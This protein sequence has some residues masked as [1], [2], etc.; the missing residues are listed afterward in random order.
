MQT[1]DFLIP[2]YDH[3]FMTL[4]GLIAK[5][6]EHPKGDALLGA[7]LAEDMLPLATQIRFL[8]NMPGE[9]LRRL[10]GIDFVSSEEDDTT[11]DQAARRVEEARAWLAAFDRTA[12]R[13][14]DY[15]AGFELPNGMAFDLTVDQYVRDWALPQFYFHLMAAYAILRSEGLTIGKADYVPYM[16]AYLRAPQPA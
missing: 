4:A 7:R 8:C 10:A 16:L 13:A 1:A 12:I 2:T 14:P 5:A 9:H 15:P 11:L 3:L 6:S